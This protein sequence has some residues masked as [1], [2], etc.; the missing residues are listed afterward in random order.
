M[1]YGAQLLAK[2]KAP[3]T[4]IGKDDLI[5]A[6]PSGEEAIDTADL[7]LK[8]IGSLTL[9]CS[10]GYYMEGTL[11]RA[12]SKP[13]ILYEIPPSITWNRLSPFVCLS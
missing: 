10:T 9:G 2:P 5:L 6:I 1:K 8:R 4:L 11:I 12:P 3:L 7:N 13:F